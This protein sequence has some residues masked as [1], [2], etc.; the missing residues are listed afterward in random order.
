MVVQ[1]NAGTDTIN[2][3][4]AGTD[5]IWFSVDGSKPSTASGDNAVVGEIDTDAVNNGDAYDVTANTGSVA[6]TTLDVA[7]L[8]AADTPNRGNANLAT[9]ITGGNGAQ[10]FIAM[11]T[12]GQNEGI[13]SITVTAAGDEFYIA[14]YDTNDQGLYIYHADLSLIHI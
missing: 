6:T 12:S 5:V 3:F 4:T 1:D 14:A 13:G 8:D 9:D 11:A 2:S 10:L 7:N